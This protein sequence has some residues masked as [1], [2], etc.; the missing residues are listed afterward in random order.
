M[1]NF[2]KQSVNNINPE[3]H[4]PN[5]FHRDS[6]PFT[7]QLGSFI[8]QIFPLLLMLFG[9]LLFI[10]PEYGDFIFAFAVGVRLATTRK[11]HDYPFDAP[12]WS[13]YIS[14]KESLGSA[15]Q[16]GRLIPK[17]EAGKGTLIFGIEYFKRRLLA[18]NPDMET[19]HSLVMGSTG[20]GKTVL[21]LTMLFQC[22]L[23]PGGTSAV[24]VDGKAD[25][26]LF[27]TIFAILK[28]LDRLHDFL[29]LNFLTPMDTLD[30]SNMHDDAL[31][32][33]NMNILNN[34]TPDQMKTLTMGL[35]RDSEGGDSSFWEG[36]TSTMIG[37]SYQYLVYERDIEGLDLNIEVVR[38]FLVL[39]NMLKKASRKDVPLK[40][41]L[42]LQQYLKTLPTISDSVFEQS[43]SEIDQMDIYTK[44]EEQHSYNVMMVSETM[45]DLSETMNHIFVTKLSEVNMTDVCL[46]GRVL[47]VLLPSIAK[48]ADSVAALGRLLLQG[49]RPILMRAAGYKLQGNRVT[50]DN[51]PSSAKYPVRLFFDEYGMYAVKGFY[52]IVSLV[53]S[54]GF[55]VLFGAQTAGMFQRVC[56]REEYEALMGNLNNKFILKNED[57]GE[58][59]SLALGRTGKVFGARQDKIENEV[60]GAVHEKDDVR[61][62]AND[63]VNAQMLASA[64]PGEGLYIYGGDVYPFKA[65]EL[66]FPEVDTSR[67][68]YFSQVLDP[69]LDEIDDAKR[70]V[71]LKNSE[72]VEQANEFVNLEM[73][74]LEFKE[75]SCDLQY[76]RSL[77]ITDNLSKQMMLALGRSVLE[78]AEEVVEEDVSVTDT[79]QESGFTES[80]DEEFG[81]ISIDDAE[82]QVIEAQSYQD[83]VAGE[84][85]EEVDFS[86]Y[87][88][89]MGI[90]PD[91]QNDEND[92]SDGNFE[93]G[94]LDSAINGEVNIEAFKNTAYEDIQNQYKN[95]YVSSNLSNEQLQAALDDSQVD[96]KETV[97]DLSL[98]G[99]EDEATAVTGAEH[100][101]SKIKEVLNYPNSELPSEPISTENVNSVVEDTLNSLGSHF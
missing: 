4:D 17:R 3:L 31:I 72:Y 101:I 71:L 91:F 49:L 18:S 40:Y 1:A 69:S 56:G 52:V 95:R 39:R 45:S 65:L 86:D 28:R 79:I 21:I 6:R 20:S 54:Y 36:R 97:I 62:E 37:A 2:K 99:G 11:D 82:L 47:L 5:L 89:Y 61:V 30:T 63:M 67:L 64:T 35:G 27:W 87:E 75:L 85:N 51:R 59:L 42:P 92:E 83:D 16:N 60:G 8:S 100:A 74:P 94:S 22:L 14:K 88:L 78:I 68:N 98:F 43:E 24:I 25:I 53:R 81:N 46:G 38:N 19:R 50:L 10:A 15:I 7:V 48:N 57:H 66:K 77:N 70:Q 13:S 93:S 23:Q 12:E 96:I 90:Q 84:Y 29:V 73:E 41:R 33:N 58:S 76:V 9:M 26:K 44:A 34:G 80:V 32:S 55:H